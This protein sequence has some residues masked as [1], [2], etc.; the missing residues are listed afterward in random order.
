MVENHK[1]ADEDDRIQ[2]YMYVGTVF[3]GNLRNRRGS[4]RTDCTGA[5]MQL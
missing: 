4:V 5:W 2:G 1:D 3:H